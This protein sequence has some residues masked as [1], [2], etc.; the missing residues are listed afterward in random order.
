M[1][2][3]SVVELENAAALEPANAER[4]FRLGLA[5]LDSG[6]LERAESSFRRVL[7][8]DRRH[9]KAGINLG[10]VLQF[11]GKGDEAESCYRDALAV[12]P[13]LA[14]GWFNL[15]TNLLARG[16]ARGAVDSLR[17]A[18]DLD[19]GRAA[20]HAVLAS[21]LAGADRA[22]EALDSARTAVG[23]DP[24]LAEAQEQLAACLQ[25]LGDHGAALAACQ[26]AIDR[27]LESQFI[28]SSLL[29][30]LSFLAQAT[31]ESVHGKH[32]ELGKR[33]AG[34][35]AVWRPDRHADPG[36]AL[37][38]GYLCPDFRDET[39]ACGLQPVLAWHDRAAYASFCYSDVE[40]E[41][42]VSWRLRAKDVNWVN[43]SFL[44][45]DELAARI[46][47]DRID[48]LVDLGGHRAGGRRIPLLAHK[49]APIQAAWL[50]YPASTG[51]AAID[52]RITD[53]RNAPAG[54][55]RHFTERLVRLPAG[56]LC[57]APDRWRS[58][59][60]PAARPS[61]AP[62]AFG[63]LHPPEAL[64]P[65]TLALWSRVLRKVPDS[66]FVVAGPAGATKY[67][68]A[69]LGVAGIEA[70]RTELVSGDARQ[71]LVERID[72]SLDAIPRAR[73]STT[74]ASLWMGVPV[75]TLQGSTA[76]ARNRA[77]LLE[78]LGLDELVAAT[79]D[80]YVDIAAAL[81]RDRPR[82]ERLRRELRGRLEQ[83][84][85]LDAQGFTRGLESAYR[86]MW[87]AYCDG[88][89]PAPMQI[90]APARVRRTPPA[91]AARGARA[92]STP[93][94]VVVD[95]VF[96]QD[97]NTG[98]ARVWSSLLEEWVRSGFAEHLVLL[99]REGSAPQIAGIRRR[100]VARHDYGRLA[101]DRDMLQLACDVEKA[102]VFVSSYY[103]RPV[104]TPCV[105][106][107]YDM[108]PEVFGVDLRAPEWRE[109]A[110][111]IANARRF[112]AIS[113]STA[114]DLAALYPA[115]DPGRVTVAYCGVAPLFRPCSVEEIESFRRRHRIE[116]PY[117]L[118]VGGRGGGYKNARAFFRALALLPDRQRLAVVW[119][120]GAH[121]LDAEEQ[122]VCAGT[123]VHL[124]RVDD[125]E[126]R[127]AY[128]AAV[129]LAYP[130]AY[131]GFGMP[132]AE[133]MACG[134]PVITT[135][136][137]SLPEV[138]GGAAITVAP[139]DVEELA[140]ALQR[141]QHSALRNDLA[142]RGIAQARQFSWARMAE[143]VAS[144]LSEGE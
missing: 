1:H 96:F 119:V 72:V 133:A 67:L 89:P 71:S 143:A 34:L 66:V 58:G 28:R 118:L 127:L 65:Q 75:V 82:L 135:S 42:V 56:E 81:A 124:L 90:D 46:R 138:T 54:A 7:R 3:S 105:M 24:G 38:I 39:I 31:P 5:Q 8:L 104:S 76:A 122:A 2:G 116:K 142:A 113:R 136:S 27:G 107:A 99:D 35:A 69:Q 21:A 55:E 134:C 44:G 23:L 62:I 85:L 121:A 18:V 144:V 4:W 14:Q 79:E 53:G 87:R 45:N 13:E 33:H 25:R 130:S 20:W 49:P 43:T 80:A 9:A 36:R 98:I 10:T 92:G 140:G 101:Q 78:D 50:G 109:K 112:V 106:L 95:G 64:T 16:R 84:T 139:T 125:E 26:A 48:I 91:A 93:C 103:S 94:R 47:G 32:V 73:P 131:E 141:V 51:L 86:Q 22:A 60:A 74:L 102:T 108:I 120:G 128:G 63:S 117:F 68:A 132:V 61:H 100:V 77:S 70:G 110:D 129:A 97:H 111:C 88:R 17:R 41:D 11:S 59:G 83:S 137:A 37:R 40:A 114:S 126:L 29:D 12:A 30:A 6:L 52:Y 57:F 123:E 15:G 19:P 115:I